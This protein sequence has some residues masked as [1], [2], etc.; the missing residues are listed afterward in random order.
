MSERTDLDGTYYSGAAQAP[1]DERKFS[2]G[3]AV[4]EYWKIRDEM[5]GVAQTPS[6][7]RIPD[8]D[9]AARERLKEYFGDAEEADHFLAWLWIGGLKVVPLSSDACPT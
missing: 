9:N 2:N 4:D 1:S 3:L 7:A 8:T 5:T 6:S